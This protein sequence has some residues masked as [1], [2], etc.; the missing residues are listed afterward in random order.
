MLGLKRRPCDGMIIV[1]AALNKHSVR[2]A[3]VK[4]GR[5][6]LG[7]YNIWFNRE[8]IVDL[9]FERSTEHITLQELKEMILGHLG[10]DTVKEFYDEALDPDDDRN[11]EE[12]LSAAQ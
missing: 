9:E 8:V 2:T 12:R 7:G 11:F 5:G 1:G 4:S 6:L 10:A 3:R